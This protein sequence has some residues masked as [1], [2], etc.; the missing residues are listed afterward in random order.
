MPDLTGDLGPYNLEPDHATAD[1]VLTQAA[2]VVLRY[3]DHRDTTAEGRQA[4][5]DVVEHLRAL[6]RRWGVTL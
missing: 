2:L 4:C 5:D 3:R 6:G 1:R